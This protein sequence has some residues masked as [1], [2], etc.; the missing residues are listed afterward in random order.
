MN[1]Q[2]ENILDDA[3]LLALSA[4]HTRFGLGAG[5][6]RLQARA[7]GGGGQRRRR[8]RGDWST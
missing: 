3:I 4:N 1:A 2:Q 8:W 6:I 7:F 5:A